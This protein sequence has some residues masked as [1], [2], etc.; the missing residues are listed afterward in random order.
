M[1]EKQPLQLIVLLLYTL[2]LPLLFG[3][4]QVKP[5]VANQA[6]RGPVIWL[7]CLL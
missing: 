5:D 3:G 2:V 6:R 4:A 7:E 1:R